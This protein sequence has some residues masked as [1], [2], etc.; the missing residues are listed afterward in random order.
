MGPLPKISTDDVIKYV[1]KAPKTHTKTTNGEVM[2]MDAASV[3]GDTRSRKLLIL[4]H[5]A[6]V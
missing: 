5:C 1:K 2:D 6:K 3:V 4:L